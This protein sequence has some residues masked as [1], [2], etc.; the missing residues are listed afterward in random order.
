MHLYILSKL[1]LKLG[2]KDVKYSLSAIMRIME[3][4]EGNLDLSYAL[5]SSL[6]NDLKIVKG[7]LDLRHTKI[8]KL[9]D[10]LTTVGGHLVLKDSQIKSL[11]DNLTVYG[12]VDVSN[13]E[14]KSLPCGLTVGGSLY[15]SNTNITC[16][17]DDLFVVGGI[18][19][20]N[21][22]IKRIKK[23]MT[24][25]KW[26]NLMGTLI[27]RLPGDLSV[28]EELDVS[29]TAVTSIPKT[30]LVGGNFDLSG[31][32]I[33]EI[34][35]NFIVGGDLCL[36]ETSI[37]NLPNGLTVGGTLDLTGTRVTDLP[38]GLA[39][40]NKVYGADAQELK[41][42]KLG[43]G[44]FIPYKYIFANGIL[45]HIKCSRRMQ[46]GYTLYTG[47]IKGQNILSDGKFFVQCNTLEEGFSE[48]YF[49]RL[50]EKGAEQYK[51]LTLDST[52]TLDEAVILY[53]IITGACR[54]GVYKFVSDIRFPKEKYTIGEIIEI[55][56]GQFGA[57]KFAQFFE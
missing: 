6:P 43:N 34:P 26:L 7:N 18:D 52:V 42:R 44:E 19:V 13:T 5:I 16:L 21:T 32:K 49:E 53:R 4:K 1:N 47:R 50:K 38:L 28:I 3:E 35:D 2:E 33:T 12:D 48:I 8:K 37:S 29:N 9:P 46:Q 55:T 30:L 11:P 56:E 23:N 14:I 54:H 41:C 10:S 51:S 20:S 25:I 36:R 57:Q 27:E 45:T 39:V 40:G 15:A 31:S 24:V 17:P 22:K